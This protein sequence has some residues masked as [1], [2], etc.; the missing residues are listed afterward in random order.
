MWGQAWQRRK[1]NAMYTVQGTDESLERQ[2]HISSNSYKV[3]KQERKHRIRPDWPTLE[4]K[5][6]QDSSLV[7]AGSQEKERKRKRRK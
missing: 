1:N 6:S 7:T 3:S 4:R 2:E 5:N